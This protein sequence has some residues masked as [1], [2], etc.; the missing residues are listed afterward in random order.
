MRRTSLRKL[1][2]ATA[3]QQFL[4]AAKFPRK[5]SPFKCL[6]HNHVLDQKTQPSIRL[7][8]DLAIEPR[9]LRSYSVPGRL[10]RERSQ[11]RSPEHF[12]APLSALIDTIVCLTPTKWETVSSQFG[13]ISIAHFVIGI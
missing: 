8:R 9:T 10:F 13:A 4:G 6:Q 3:V 5:S 2:I 1:L 7:F 11:D 12:S